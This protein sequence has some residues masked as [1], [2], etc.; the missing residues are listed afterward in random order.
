M[1]F[2]KPQNTILFLVIVSL[3]AGITVYFGIGL[4]FSLYRQV[5]ASKTQTNITPT[6]S[7]Q[8][9]TNVTQTS[10]AAQNI[11]TAINIPKIGKNLPIKPASVHG[12][13]WDMFPDAVAWLAT[14]AVPG[15]GNV[16]LYAHDWVTLWGDLYLLKPGD[17]VEIQYNNI[18]KH[19]VVSE[20]RDVDQ[21]DVQSI[22][23][24]KNQL[25]LYT[26][27]GSFDQ[28]RKVVYASPAD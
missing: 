12:N 8:S 25:T 2:P 28:K 20:S 9:A 4:L 1:K 6:V 14:S 21:H 16:I 27:E 13:N 10:T 7:T 19:Y 18:W 26:C 5:K 17:A 11:P 15:Q 24:D 3:V 23:S 22:L